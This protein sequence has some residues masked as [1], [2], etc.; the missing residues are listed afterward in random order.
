[1]K[2]FYHTAN[3]SLRIKRNP[4]VVNKVNREI[5]GQDPEVFEDKGMVDQVIASYFAEIYI[6]PDYMQA[7]V[8]QEVGENAD[9]EDDSINTTALFQYDI[10]LATLQSN[11]KRVLDWTASMEISSVRM[12]SLRISSHPRR[13]KLA[14]RTA[15]LLPSMPVVS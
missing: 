15:S 7:Q 6:R 5:E 9:M 11:F 8:S 2:E 4:P 3:K 12:S 10:R 1:M 14:S 13:I